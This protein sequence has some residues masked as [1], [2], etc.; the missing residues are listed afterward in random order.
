VFANTKSMANPA[1]GTNHPGNTPLCK[2]LD[3]L[4]NFP[5]PTLYQLGET[6][7]FKSVVIL[8]IGLASDIYRNEMGCS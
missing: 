2:P 4:A 7:A 3:G 5:N 8:L 1:T 6:G